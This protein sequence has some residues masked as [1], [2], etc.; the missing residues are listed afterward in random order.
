MK[1]LHPLASVLSL[2]LLA[3][4]LEFGDDTELQGNQIDDANLKR[5]TEI[6]GV[7]FPAGTIG[8]NYFYQ[9]SGI[10]DAMWFKASI[11]LE[12]KS[13]F[14]KNVVFSEVDDAPN[15]NMTLD[16]DWWKIDTL[17]EVSHYS[18]TINQNTDFL[19][20]SIGLESGEVTFYLLWFST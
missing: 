20:C 1:S 19:G 5:I 14:L 13:E 2:A 15:H 6:T 9:G 8:K 18:T 16:R 17:K 10:D 11:P 4:C 12:E 7:T 3:G